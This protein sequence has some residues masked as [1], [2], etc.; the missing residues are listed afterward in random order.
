MIMMIISSCVKRVKTL[1][2]R[3]NRAW[4]KLRHRKKS[5][6]RVENLHPA[7]SIM[8]NLK[9]VAISRLL[10]LK[11]PNRSI[12]CIINQT[13]NWIWGRVL[14]HLPLSYLRPITRNRKLKDHVQQRVKILLRLTLC[15]TQLQDK[16]KWLIQHNLLVHLL[17]KDPKQ[18]RVLLWKPSKPTISITAQWKQ[19]KRL[20]SPALVF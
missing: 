8:S 12:C 18:R 14:G 16:G 19:S 13:D 11:L 6:R 1:L 5:W 3:F 7:S 4:K 9:L 2:I 17:E 10:R 15:R 20:Q